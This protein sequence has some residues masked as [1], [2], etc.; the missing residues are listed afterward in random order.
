MIKRTLCMCGY[1]V[2][3]KF[4]NAHRYSETHNLNIAR[5]QKAGLLPRPKVKVPQ[6]LDL[7]IL[8]KL[9]EF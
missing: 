7:E 9:K 6:I 4:A 2:P 1:F 5:L 3:D 8:L